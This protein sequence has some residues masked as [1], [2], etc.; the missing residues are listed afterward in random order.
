MLNSVKSNKIYG[1]CGLLFILAV[2]TFQYLPAETFNFKIDLLGRLVESRAVH[3]EHDTIPSESIT[4]EFKRALRN[5]PVG[6]LVAA[7]REATKLAAGG[8]NESTWFTE[9]ARAK[10]NAENPCL[11]WDELPVRYGK[12]N[13]VQDLEPSK[14]W[15]VVL[16]EYARLQQQ[17]RLQIHGHRHGGRRIG[18]Q[19]S[20]DRFG[21][22]VRRLDAARA[23]HLEA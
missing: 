19:D 1:I 20:D 22:C 18:E 10:W 21:L 3:R 6:E 2:F 17:R 11:S 5:E 16:R 9:E 23:P 8:V 14:N 7:L 15:Q 13:Y 12:R 4:K